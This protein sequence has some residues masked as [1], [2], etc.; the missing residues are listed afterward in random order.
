MLLS[1]FVILS[2]CIFNGLKYMKWT[3]RKNL[4]SSLLIILIKPFTEFL[5]NELKIEILTYSTSIDLITQL[6]SSLIQLSILYKIYW[7]DLSRIYW[8]LITV[9]VVELT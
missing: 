3:Q 6:D 2:G 8:E 4:L 5:D 9:L 1:A 7:K